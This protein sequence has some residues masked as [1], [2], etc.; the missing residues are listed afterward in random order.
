MSA[1]QVIGRDEELE[2]LRRFLDAVPEAPVALVIEG[3][4]GV[5]KTALWLQGTGLARQRSFRIL[6]CRPHRPDTHINPATVDLGMLDSWPT[7]PARPA[8]SPRRSNVP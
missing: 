2:S 6:A 4:A 3:E 1:S 5:G 7:P 8:A